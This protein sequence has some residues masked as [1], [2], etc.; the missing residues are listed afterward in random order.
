MS[1][2]ENVRCDLVR[3]AP[4]ISSLITHDKIARFA[5]RD[6]MERLGLNHSGLMP[7]D[8]ITLPHFSV[9]SATSLPKSA[10]RDEFHLA[11]IVQNLKTLANSF[12]R[13]R[14]NKQA[15]CVA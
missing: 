12:W 13:P 7:A 1:A 10:A 4:Q 9:S 8:L 14:P 3:N 11:A 15:A 5:E 2:A 6:V